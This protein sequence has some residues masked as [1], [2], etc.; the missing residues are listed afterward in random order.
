MMVLVATNKEMQLI[1]VGENGLGEELDVKTITI[2]I[3]DSLT[4]LEWGSDEAFAARASTGG[5]D[6]MVFSGGDLA[7]EG[8]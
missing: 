8:R 5:G 3:P 7:R 4:P 1:I 2:E 6:P